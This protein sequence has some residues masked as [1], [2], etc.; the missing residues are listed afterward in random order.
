[1]KTPTDDFCGACHCRRRWTA[2]E[3]SHRAGVG[4]DVCFTGKNFGITRVA[5]VVLAEKGPQ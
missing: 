3:Q 2:F 5:L 1:M 4:Y